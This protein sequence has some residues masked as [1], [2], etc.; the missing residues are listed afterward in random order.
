MS[1]SSKPKHKLTGRSFSGLIPLRRAQLLN[2]GLI[3]VG[4][5]IYIIL[6][7]LAAPNPNLAGDLNNDNKVDV[8]DLSI[9]LSSY[10]S[11]QAGS[12]INADGQVNI[13]DLSILLSHY[14]SNGGITTAA[15]TKYA[16]TS[17][18]DA[19][20]GTQAS[21]YKT[22]QVLVNNLKA[23][24]TGCI[25][26]G[27]Y[28]GDVSVSGSGTSASPITL[29]AA[30]STARPTI[31]G[32]LE[33]KDS[34]NYVNVNNI[35]FDSTGVSQA[36]EIQVFGDYFHLSNCNVWSPHESRIGIVFGDANGTYGIAQHPEVDHCRIY[37]FGI[38]G[39]G[40]GEG[41]DHG[42]YDQASRFAS[43]HDNYLYDNTGGWGVQ[44]W[45][46]AMNGT[47]QHNIIDRNGGGIIIAGAN[48]TTG[49]PSSNNT[50]QNNII[51]NPAATWDANVRYNITAYWQNA[52][53]TGN[54]VKD[55][56]LWGT[57]NI[58]YTGGWSMS[59]LTTTDPLYVDGANHNYALKAGSP[60]AAYAPDK[61]LP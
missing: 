48:S 56:C 19:N 11:T 31:H 8:T 13:L 51:S 35:N 28:S 32:V 22:V 23:G 10:N 53:G 7:S 16:S 24:N 40:D 18:N 59:N 46:N 1:K 47:Y 57:P 38:I 15:C 25:M 5:G 26:G 55:G 42:I 52:P 20:P 60:C 41:H 29:T 2:F 61:V 49:G 30:S 45:T 54:V 3:F 21:P 12:D 36:V 17:G 14:G 9:L 44:L 33:V 39:L 43:V 4:F 37:G 6:H 50:F 27:T 34:A 58:G